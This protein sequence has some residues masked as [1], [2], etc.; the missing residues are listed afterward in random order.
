MTDIRSIK[1]M[2]QCETLGIPKGIKKCNFYF[3][4]FCLD[5]FSEMK[6]QLLRNAKQKRHIPAH[7]FAVI[8]RISKIN[9]SC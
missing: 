3:Y 1:E 7:N 9:T 2:I 5:F 4:C 6:I 8:G